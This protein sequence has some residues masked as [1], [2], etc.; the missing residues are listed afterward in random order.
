MPNVCEEHSGHI[1]RIA[2]LEKQQDKQ[3][4]IIDQMKTWVILGMGGLLVQSFFFIMNL[5][6]KGH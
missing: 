1:V 6:D 5:L 3:W 2:E 4:R